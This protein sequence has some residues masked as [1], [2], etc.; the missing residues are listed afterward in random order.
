MP[1]LYSIDAIVLLDKPTG[2]SSN[3]ALQ[4]VKRLLGARK[5][6]HGGSLDPLASGML[7][8]CLG[9]AT[10][11]AGPM[12]AGR[13]H[14]EF[15]LHL[16]VE[17]S[18][19][20]LEGEIVGN[21]PVPHLTP[22][23]VRRVLSTFVGRR[24][25]IPPMHSALRRG[26]A[27]L[28][29]LARRGIEVARAPRPIDIDVFE[30]IGLEDHELALR[31]TCSKGTYIRTLGQDVAAALGTCGHIDHLRRLWVEPFAGEPMV[32]LE[33]LERLAGS[34]VELG[35]WLLP[36]DRGIENWP[37]VDLDADEARRMLDGQTLDL[38]AAGADE[39][40]IRVYGP[41]GRFL[42]IAHR[43]ASGRVTPRRLI[44]STRDRIAI[45]DVRQSADQ[46][47]PRS[48]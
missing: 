4:Q 38:P 19:G 20:D 8:I 28:Y 39:A 3:A 10:K 36:V 5:A 29:E 48:S 40:A 15:R 45:S 42:G 41:A 7:P 33:E 6:G 23:N 34:P 21:Q 31:V 27:R 13:K 2:L 17:T 26:G 32:K 18:T 12:L 22:E 24:E 9:E 14:Y 25:Q 35:R 44:A 11:L 46:R 30:L 16:G 47:P 37:R 43:D 1:E